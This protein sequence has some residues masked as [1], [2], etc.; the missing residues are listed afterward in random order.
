MGI[1]T[2]QGITGWKFASSFGVECHYQVK[3]ESNEHT[4]FRKYQADK[5]EE[6]KEG[7]DVDKFGQKI[8]KNFHTN[9]APK[10]TS[11]S[12]PNKWEN[13]SKKASLVA[14]VCRSCNGVL[15]I[16]HCCCR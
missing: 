6:Q 2:F 14:T 11:P 4:I 8:R 13:F 12:S 15:L 5:N 1:S 10:K 16:V 7:C 3:K 9:I